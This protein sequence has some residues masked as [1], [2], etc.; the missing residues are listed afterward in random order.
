[1]LEVYRFLVSDGFYEE[2]LVCLC[3][4]E[5]G[6]KLSLIAN[7][8]NKKIFK[9]KCKNKKRIIHI[10]GKNIYK[11]NFSIIINLRLL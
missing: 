5:F 6:I 2:F 7:Y 10:F 8:T 9:Q 11:D 1:M 4:R 3:N